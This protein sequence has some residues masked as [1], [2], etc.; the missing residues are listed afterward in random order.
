MDFQIQ[1]EFLGT[2][3]QRAQIT[4]RGK[5]GMVHLPLEITEWSSSGSHGIRTVEGQV[6]SL[7]DIVVEEKD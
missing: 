3:R 6:P 2:A 4:F 1:V 7:L 5:E